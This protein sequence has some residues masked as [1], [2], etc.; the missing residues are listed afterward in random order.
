MVIQAQALGQPVARLQDKAMLCRMPIGMW[1]GIKSDKAVRDAGAAHFGADAESFNASKHLIAQDEIKK[2][3]SRRAF[4]RSEWTRLTAP[5]F[6]DGTR[7]VLGAGFVPLRQKVSEWQD[8]WN[9]LVSDFVARYPYL[10]EDQRRKLGPRFNVNEYPH[11]NVIAERFYFKF[12]AFALP[13]PNVT[14]DWRAD[15]LSQAD[16]DAIK[17][18]AEALFRQQIAESQVDA[19][20]RLREP[21]AHMAESLANYTGGQK[22]SFQHTLIGNLADVIAILPAINLTGDPLLEGIAAIAG[23]LTIYTAD[24]LRKDEDARK[25]SAELARSLVDQIDGLF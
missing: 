10:R 5:W 9:V 8:E 19:W 3:E 12:Q 20:R 22:G 17:A 6:D 25:S 18:D 23:Q 21:L 1:R 15:G 16:L 4:Y 11:P 7:I 13:D 14:P 2:L 24:E